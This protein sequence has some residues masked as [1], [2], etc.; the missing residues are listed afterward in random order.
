MNTGQ[1]PDPPEPYAVIGLTAGATA[2]EIT[3]AY[4]RAVR[5]C[6]PDAP[7]P[8]RERLAA[9]IAANHRL[10]DQLA[11]RPSEHQ[12]HPETR[13]ETRPTGGRDIPVGV[14]LHI[15]A[16]TRSARRSRPAPP[17]PAPITPTARGARPAPA[18]GDQQVGWVR[19]SPHGGAAGSEYVPFLDH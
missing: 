18:V 9:V 6:H 12:R 17:R 16:H 7:H 4:R 2:A 8:D 10:R 14:R 11:D 3:A 19:R 13:P 15:A 1:P 5:D